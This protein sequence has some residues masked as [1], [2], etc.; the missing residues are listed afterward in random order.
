MNTEIESPCEYCKPLKDVVDNKTLMTIM[1]PVIVYTRLCMLYGFLYKLE[2][3][4]ALAR[5]ALFHTKSEVKPFKKSADVLATIH[6]IIYMIIRMHVPGGIPY[7]S[8]LLSRAFVRHACGYLFKSLC[9][10]VL[11]IKAR[12]SYVGLTPY[13]VSYYIY[14]TV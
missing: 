3:Y 14:N 13:F 12:G 11:E 7:G 4:I 1:I 2:F 5:G 8:P 9:S 6:S 10:F